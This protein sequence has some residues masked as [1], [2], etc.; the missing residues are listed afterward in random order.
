VATASRALE[1]R[2]PTSLPVEAL[3][4][5]VRA[6]AD[7]TVAAQSARFFKTGPGEYGAGD[8]FLGIRVPDLRALVR[9]FQPCEWTTA[10]ELLES[11]WH[12][13][14]LF[15]LLLLVTNFARAKD[16]ERL[17][18]HRRYVAAIGTRVDN[19]DLVDT[20]APAIVG[21]H[22][23]N[24]SRRPLR[25]LARS[26]NLWERRVAIVATLHFIRKGELG[27]TL[28]V[29]SLLLEDPHD[30]IHKATGWMLREV[31]KRDRAVLE[32]FLEEHSARMPRTMLRYALERLPIVT[33]QRFLA[34]GSKYG[35]G[36]G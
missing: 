21:A 17:E 12:E 4:G 16:D 23:E 35:G 32:A 5:R 26:R 24:R 7:P 22:L 19:W 25:K 9:E 30:L 31:G 13:E 34:R 14:R 1:M 27:E 29:A 8:R 2:T 36:D 3:R 28:D 18:I 11:S 15:A 6:L 33:R 20:S 10:F